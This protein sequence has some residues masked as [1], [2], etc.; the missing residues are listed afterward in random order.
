MNKAV[1]ISCFNW[2]E[3]RLKPIREL[4]IEQGFEVSV[5]LSD[6]DHIKKKVVDP[7]FDECTYIHVPEYKTNISFARIISH[8]SFGLNC[9]KIIDEEKPGFIYC[10]I[11]PNKIAD[12]C[13][14]YKKKNPDVKFIIDI[15]D[16][17]PESM[18]LGKL[19]YTFPARM[20]RRWRDDAIGAADHVFTECE[21]Y[22]D[23]LEGILPPSKTSTL[24]L[25]KEQTQEECKLVEKNILK[26]KTDEVIR[27]AYLGSMNNIIDIDGIC[28]VLKHTMENGYTCELVAIGDGENRE[29]FEKAVSTIGCKATFHGA[30]YDEMKKI[31]LLAPCDYAFNM[32]KKSVSV[33]LTIKSIDYMS[34]GLPLINNIEGDTWKIVK[35]HNVGINV[36]DLKFPLISMNHAEIRNVFDSFFSREAF[37]NNLGLDNLLGRG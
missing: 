25:Y 21:L 33:G 19:R 7:R 28:E 36:C 30:I 34:Y 15:I 4:L 18:P 1:L 26:K 6:F 37:N 10:L 9:R 23:K 22:Q 3:T 16:L 24:H 32:M 27:F 5:L 31:E 8:L 20:W 12:Y 2:Y 13:A 11:P 14:S 17:W 29:R 35:E